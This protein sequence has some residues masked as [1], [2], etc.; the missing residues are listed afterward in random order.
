MDKG[1]PN[2][3]NESVTCGKRG[4]P[5][6]PKLDHVGWEREKEGEKEREGEGRRSSERLYILSRFYDIGLSVSGEAKGKVFPRDKS[7]K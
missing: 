6:L 1:N 4:H 2:K 7:C 5:T 3:A